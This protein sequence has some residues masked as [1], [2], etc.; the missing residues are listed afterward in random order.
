MRREPQDIRARLDRF[1]VPES[2]SG[3]WLW[4]GALSPDG[5]G[6]FSHG[7]PV[8][9]EYAHRAMYRLVVGEIPDGLQLDH[10]CRNRACVNPAHL[11]PVT[12]QENTLRG[13]GPA[14]VNAL[15]TE[16]DR[17]HV[18]DEANTRITSDGHRKCRKCN[19]D[20]MRAKRAGD[21]C[22]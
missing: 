9:H 12:S 3:C 13:V 4:I 2:M 18:L 7:M 11:E 19:R 21:L 8:R 22:L 10:K 5:Y 6:R 14:A 20:R 1:T 15:K 17:G 16:C